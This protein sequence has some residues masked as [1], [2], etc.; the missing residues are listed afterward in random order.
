MVQPRAPSFASA[1]TTIPVL[2]S[3]EDL[4]FSTTSPN[5][6]QAFGT[7][8]LDSVVE[9]QGDT[10]SAADGA[11]G[12]T[13]ACDH[14]GATKPT[15]AQ[16][17][18]AVGKAFADEQAPPY[19]EQCRGEGGA[20]A[21]N[22]LGLETLLLRAPCATRSMEADVI[23]ATSGKVDAH[24]AGVTGTCFSTPTSST[25][26]CT[27]SSTAA[28]DT[29]LAGL[30]GEW[31]D[32]LRPALLGLRKQPGLCCNDSHGS[33]SEESSKANETFFSVDVAAFSG[34]RRPNVL[35]VATKVSFLSA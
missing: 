29:R 17:T 27:T 14:G 35:G 16:A 9:E 1:H 15:G 28:K 4:T 21:D 13:V 34:V 10:A 22:S 5:L 12:A 25:G 26:M 6:A 30:V 18:F 31:S 20:A 24:N 8:G 32:A 19:V 33:S 3:N 11:D 2:A 7:D 23:L